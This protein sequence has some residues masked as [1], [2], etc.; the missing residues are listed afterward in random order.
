MSLSERRRFDD[1]E[2]IQSFGFC[3]NPY[4]GFQ[5][6]TINDINRAL[7]QAGDVFLERNIVVDSYICFRVEFNQDVGIAVWTVITTHPRAEQGG[8]HDPRAR[9]AALFCRRRA[10]MSSRFMMLYQP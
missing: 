10:T 7:E 8:M 2:G 3:R 1:L 9:K 5:G 4:E 6:V